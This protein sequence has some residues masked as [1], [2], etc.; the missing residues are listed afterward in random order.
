MTSNSHIPSELS[1][2]QWTSN[3]EGSS[4]LDFLFLHDVWTTFGR[5]ICHKITSTIS[6]AWNF[7]T[8]SGGICNFFLPRKNGDESKLWHWYGI[9]ANHLTQR[10]CAPRALIFLLVLP[11]EPVKSY[12]VWDVDY[13]KLFH[14]D[15]RKLIYQSP[16]RV[17]DPLIKATAQLFLERTM[18]FPNNT[19]GWRTSKPKEFQDVCEL[20][21]V[22]VARSFLVVARGKQGF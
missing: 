16:F 20:V 9:V 2:D 15:I 8:K 10:G 4:T 22:T 3:V 1:V 18:D 14:P 17:Y 13:A 5:L 21:F 19:G 6:T 7:T 11:D 12:H